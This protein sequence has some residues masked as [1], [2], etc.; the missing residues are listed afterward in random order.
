M[1]K[2]TL[3][4]DIV[5]PL[6]A[7]LTDAN[8]AHDRAVDVAA[9]AQE[10]PAWAAL[11]TVRGGVPTDERLRV[12]VGGV[13]LPN[14]LIMPAGFDKNARAALTLHRLGF[15]SVIV[16]T[17]LTHP[18]SGNPLP[19][20]FRPEPGVVLN[21]MG[22]P[23]EGLRAV[24]ARLPAQAGRGFPLGVS[25][26]INKDVSPGE[27]PAAYAEVVRATAP[28]ADYFEINVS[29]PN[30]PGLRDLQNREHLEAIIAAIQGETALPL[31]VK[32]SPDLT[33]HAVDDLLDVA[34]SHGIAAIAAT[35]TTANPLLKAQLGS[36]WA[37]EAGGVSGPP[38]R[39]RA[40]EM[41][42][43]IAGQAGSRLD[44]VGVGGVT[45]FPSLLEKL[46]AGAKAVGIYTGFVTHGPALP[47]YLLHQLLG[48]MQRE[49]VPS[50][51]AIPRDSGGGRDTV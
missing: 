31:W 5:Y 19:T 47:S 4:R 44:V 24:A 35:N 27:A 2:V 8:R 50:V 39:Q 41:V 32:V 11:G 48:W 22:F 40:T 28:H 12:R 13:E 51:A 17:L 36:R 25:V 21:R 1:N 38:L 16:G 6:L 26:G 49:G 15:G 43:H 46:R 42:A 14:P 20:I 45:D 3:Y 33:R 37:G 18:Q 29:S 7:R 23:S 34:L 30:T 10:R 9:W